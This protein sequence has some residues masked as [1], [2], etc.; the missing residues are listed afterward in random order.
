MCSFQNN[1]C[2]IQTLQ[3]ETS[4]SLMRFVLHL[5]HNSQVV[6]T[7]SINAFLPQIASAIRAARNFQFRF[8]G[9]S[10][11][12]LINALYILSLSGSSNDSSTRTSIPR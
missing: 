10:V 1:K 6:D 7:C 12:E 2:V 11:C 9:R 5:I 3:N 8:C 4:T